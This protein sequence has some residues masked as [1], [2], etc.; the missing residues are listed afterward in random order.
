M[1]LILIR[2]SAEHSQQGRQLME[3]KLFMLS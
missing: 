1:T 3:N 2:H